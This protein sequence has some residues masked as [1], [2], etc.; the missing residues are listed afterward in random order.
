MFV[1]VTKGIC[2]CVANHVER[3][4]GLA[5]VAKVAFVV[6][7]EIVHHLPRSSTVT[8]TPICASR[9]AATAPPNPLPTI[10]AVLPVNDA[11][12]AYVGL[13][14]ITAPADDEKMICGAI[15]TPAPIA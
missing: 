6:G 15:A 8:F 7:S 3:L 5:T 10:T 11:F 1:G 12:A 2:V 14:G 9:R 4:S 13:M